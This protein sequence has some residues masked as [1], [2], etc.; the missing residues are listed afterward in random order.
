MNRSIDDYLRAVDHVLRDQPRTVRVLHR[1][2]VREHLSE[3]DPLAF[4][5]FASP[6]QYAA[7]YRSAR[8]FPER[9][10]RFW[11]RGIR[12]S[13]RMAAITVVLIVAFV[14]G[15]GLWWSRYQPFEASLSGGRNTVRPEFSDAE[16]AKYVDG[17]TFDVG[18]VVRNSGPF[19]GDIS[20]VEL[21]PTL[22]IGVPFQFTRLW[23]GTARDPFGVDDP[24]QLPHR[25]A[26]HG[27]LYLMMR[28]TM[29]NCE[30]NMPGD[31]TTVSPKLGVRANV[32]GVT[33]HF[34]V[35]PHVTFGVRIPVGYRCPR[36][37][38]A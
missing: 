17:G 7:E 10:L 11:W 24:S 30:F 33:R 20:N 1:D 38:K 23:L 3:Y 27:E 19:V 4:D 32:L 5:T 25:L 9:R 15:S 21:D 16:I 34:V 14:A 2:G 31:Y 13:T 28:F 26:Q 6:A 12:R 35:D 29:T 18:F 36:L 37:R 8:A 22:P